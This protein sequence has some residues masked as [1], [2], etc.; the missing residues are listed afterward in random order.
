MSTVI[1]EHPGWAGYRARMPNLL[2]VEER[3][4]GQ[5]GS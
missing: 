1:D 2:V 4:T 5:P 3:G